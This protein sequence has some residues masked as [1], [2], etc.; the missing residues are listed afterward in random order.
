[1][2]ESSRN[3]YTIKG[4]STPTMTA[5]TTVNMVDK[6]FGDSANVCGTLCQKVVGFYRGDST[7]NIEGW[8]LG[9]LFH[10]N[11]AAVKTPAQY[12][13][14]PREC[15]GTSFASF[16]G[17]HIR[18]AA[19]RLQLM[20]V[21]AND[22]QLHAFRTGNGSSCGG[23]GD[24]AWSFIPP[25]LLQK[26]APIA[27]NDHTSRVS[28]AS[29]AYF[30]DG[31]IQVADVWL[32]S[33]SSS[34]T[35]KSASEWRT[36][37]IFGEGQG[38]GNYL[39]STS[40]TCFS[41]STSGYSATYDSTYYK[42][43]C[44][45]YALDVTNTSATTPTLLGMLDTSTSAAAR[46]LGEPWSKVQ[47]GRVMDN[48]NEKWVAFIGGG[49]SDLTCLSSDGKIST[50]CDTPATG[51]A[52]KGFFVIDLANNGAIL[53]S[54]THYNNSNMDF[55][56]PASPLPLDLDGDGFIDTVYMGDLGGNMWRFRFCPKDEACS[57]CGR[58][59]GYTSTPCTNCTHNNWTGSRLFASTNT[60]RGYDLSTPSSASKQIFTSAAA[61]KDENGQVLV[62]F[63]TGQNNDPT[64]KP[65]DDD[66][67]KNRLYMV[68]E[69]FDL[70][71]TY[72]SSDLTN[73]TDTV[74]AY[75]SATNYGWYINLSTNSVTLSDNTTIAHP[76]GE[77]MI[78]D[79][80][81][82]GGYAYFPT[83][84]PDQGTSSACGLAGNAVLYELNYLTGAGVVNNGIKKTESTN[85]DGET[86]V[87]TVV[88]YTDPETGVTTRTTTVT[89][90]GV[91]TT[92]TETV[93]TVRTVHIGQGIGSS[94]LVSYRP[95]Y[96]EAD[97]YETASGGAGRATLTQQVGQAPKSSSM[98][99]LLYW[100]DRRLQ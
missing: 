96:T 1:V 48:G 82:F 11:P 22:G 77:K 28:L 76:V 32:P 13:Y 94:V 37:A 17:S 49:F 70:T 75:S 27:H 45:Y 33:T 69:M 85:S 80:T 40:P 87:T 52:G 88:T 35:S 29:H 47:I 39:W 90:G 31:P 78:S 30:I 64:S 54:Y 44:G 34:G 98:T 3:M 66:Y 14:D 92:T 50:S 86:V 62:F 73:I 63:G 58:T 9:D 42:Y 23:G 81:I 65:E 57:D 26:M 36:I 41:D 25:N 18:T 91:S 97:I 83:Y 74:Y 60:E 61:A 93:P 5:F 56:A 67:T 68:K 4:S 8:K 21:G 10:T 55:S 24:E 7:Y 59:A 12:F 46:Y 2:P 53:W 100:K 19:D 20:L 99:N 16:R 38:A 6:D 43:Y 71:K 51:S 95:G 72:T 84:I 15:Y 79:P 89:V